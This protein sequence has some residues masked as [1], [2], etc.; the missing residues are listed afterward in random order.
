M[1]RSLLRP[2]ALSL[3]V[4]KQPTHF[5]RASTLAPTVD[6][7]DFAH[8]SRL[9]DLRRAL[10]DAGNSSFVWSNY[11][12]L[13]SS[14][15]TEGLPLELHQEVLRRCTPATDEVRKDILRSLEAKNRTAF[16]HTHESRFQFVIRNIRS[17][18]AEPSL[19]DYHFVLE[20]FAAVGHYV[21]AFQVFKELGRAGHTP[22]SR[23][24]GLCLQSIAH[25]YQLPIYKKERNTVLEETQILFK[26]YI[27][28]MRRHQ[29]AFTAANLDLTL[30]ILKETL[31]ASGFEALMRW[32]YAIDLSNPD[33]LALEY[34]GATSSKTDRPPVPFPFTT[35]SLNTTIDMLG[36]L[37]DVSKLVQAFEVFT[38]PLPQAEQHFFNTF[39]EDDDDFG[40]RVDLPSTP[41]SVPSATPNT[42][43]Y[44]MLLRHLSR[45]GH[46]SLCRHY[47]V[48]AIRLDRQLELNLRQSIQWHRPQGLPLDRIPAPQFSINRGMFL[49][50]L[51][52]ANKEK[53]LRL[54]KWMQERLNRTMRNK[55]H[56][57]EYHTRVRQSRRTILYSPKTQSTPSEATAPLGERGVSDSDL[58]A[59]SKPPPSPQVKGL[60]LD[61]HVQLLN[62]TLQ[63]LKDFSKRLEFVLGRTH[64]R[65]KERL[66]RRVWNGKPI[67]LA[68]R[69]DRVVV[70]K[71]EWRERVNFKP[72]KSLK[73]E[74]KGADSSRTPQLAKDSAPPSKGATEVKRRTSPS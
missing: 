29:I 39:E 32:G 73:G 19:D 3:R 55:Q 5:H 43:T 4:Q 58:D 46:R 7:L 51:A 48:E 8:Q 67:Y 15:S 47:L 30:R 62:K 16:S 37:N 38:Q 63:E 31:D 71:D 22:T 23:T 27:E 68:N 54:M 33:R 18:G 11:T 52:Y 36:R 10:D 24:I 14:L 74:D 56:D 69:K 44:T 72:R 26:N 34:S 21:G 35:S 6:P 65:V 42:T 57:L 60:D 53:D 50:V 64:Q 25:R 28:S 13:L 45:I 61:L 9:Q 2:I 20:Q 12:N 17:L 66:G 1:S 41:L 40:V 59:S 49:S 70:T